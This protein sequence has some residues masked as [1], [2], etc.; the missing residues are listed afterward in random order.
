[1]AEVTL[2]GMKRLVGGLFRYMEPDGFGP[3]AS[4]LQEELETS[5][6]PKNFFVEY[7]RGADGGGTLSMVRKDGVQRLMWRSPSHARGAS[8]EPVEQGRGVSV[9]SLLA[10]RPLP[11]YRQELA[12]LYLRDA[13]NVVSSAR[14]LGGR[15]EPWA[16]YWYQS[17]L[18]YVSPFAR[19][20]VGAPLVGEEHFKAA[21]FE[22]GR[23]P[24]Q[25]QT[26][27]S[28]AVGMAVAADVLQLQG[29]R[30]DLQFSFM[31]HNATDGYV[32]ASVGRVFRNSSVIVVADS[33]GRRRMVERQL[34][35]NR[36]SNSVVV[37]QNHLS[38]YARVV[39]L[40][41]DCSCVTIDITTPRIA[42][43]QSRTV[44]ILI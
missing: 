34:R 15:A 44:L 7:K 20:G 1:M 4:P 32:A 37:V 43:Q 41:P 24:E 6:S 14:N 36:V 25:L 42:P 2:L 19:D 3:H 22:G 35:K 26:V 18:F 31:E 23:S 29:G 40:G 12:H 28:L 8:P 38:D 9:F 10:V 13:D 21:V 30:S 27:L 11:V 16:T 39:T 17:T 5:V 33:D